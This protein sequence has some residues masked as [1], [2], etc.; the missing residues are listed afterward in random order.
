MLPKSQL[1]KP[2][3]LSILCAFLYAGVAKT[4]T[5]ASCP[6]AWYK[7]PKTVYLI[8]IPIPSYQ[9][10][11]E[12]ILVNQKGQLQLCAG[13]T[14]FLPLHFPLPLLT[15]GATDPSIVSL[16]L[17]SPYISITSSSLFKPTLKLLLGNLKK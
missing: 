4:R 6:I 9:K 15:F 12:T 10:I 16:I 14:P 7:N 2:P 13:S 1:S 17:Y 5:V 8:C 11:P 3:K